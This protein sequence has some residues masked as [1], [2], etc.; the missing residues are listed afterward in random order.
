MPDFISDFFLFFFIFLSAQYSY[1]MRSSQPG[2][3]GALA[4]YYQRASPVIDFVALAVIWGC[5]VLVSNLVDVSGRD[6]NLTTVIWV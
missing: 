3:P 4:R 2:V 6:E 5:S 1:D